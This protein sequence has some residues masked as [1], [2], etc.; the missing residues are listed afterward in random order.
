MLSFIQRSGIEKKVIALMKQ[1]GEMKKL[2]E[3]FTSQQE[4]TI[5]IEVEFAATAAAL[6]KKTQ[7]F[8]VAMA[9]LEK[10]KTMCKIVE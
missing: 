1:K 8:K 3:K 9:H 6:E 2:L 5:D 7:Q 4:K 10:E